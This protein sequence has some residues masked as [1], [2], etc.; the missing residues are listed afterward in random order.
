MILASLKKSKMAMTGHLLFNSIDN[1]NSAT[2][3]KNLLKLLE[4][5]KVQWIANH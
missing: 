4:K 2:H 1:K 5:Y 3:S